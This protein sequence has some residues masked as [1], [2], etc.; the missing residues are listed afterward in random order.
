LAIYKITPYAKVGIVIVLALEGS[1][2]TETLTEVV[3]YLLVKACSIHQSRIS[4]GVETLCLT[5]VYL[6]SV[7]ISYV[8]SI[9][10][11]HKRA[12]NPVPPPFSTVYSITEVGPV[13]ILAV[14]SSKFFKLMVLLK[15]KGL[16]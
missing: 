2:T 4:F 14:D 11:L 16:S 1:S 6:P 9:E 3:I 12:K 15:T 8:K 7:D 10:V 5:T 13:L